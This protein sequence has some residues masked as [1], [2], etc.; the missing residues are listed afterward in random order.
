M[1][2]L[3]LD[4]GTSGARA[5]AINRSGQIHYHHSLPYQLDRET[6]WQ[7]AL[8]GLLAQIPRAVA[9]RLAKVLIAATS[10][11][12]LGVDG[13]GHP[14]TPILPYFDPRASQISLPG[15]QGN[16][17]ASSLAKL[18]WLKAH[19]QFTYLSH[20]A[21]YLGYLL[22]GQVGQSDYHNCL[23]L[24][25]DPVNLKFP[26]WI[27]QL[28]VW[29]Y[30]PQVSFPGRTVGRLLPSL[31]DRF[32]IAP[33]CEICAGTTDSTGAVLATLP[34][35]ALG[36]GITSL[37][38]TLVLKLVSDRPITDLTHGIY[39]HRL[40]YQGQTFYLV[41][42]ASNTGGA[43]LRHFFEDKELQAYSG[44]IDLSQPSPYDYY[45]LLRPGDRF[46]TNDPNLLPRLEP[47]PEDP[48]AF[49]YGLLSSIA[50][51]EA[52]GYKLLQQLTGTPITQIYTNG[53]GAANAT[54]TKIRS[55]YLGII[56][57]TPVQTQ[58]AYGAAKLALK[59]NP[60]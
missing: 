30:L 59:T 45:P 47:R 17:P 40:D 4:F 33:E 39:S 49:L 60:N 42:G 24:G 26:D 13:Q 53:G 55:T 44:L 28:P 5:I 19:Y 32:G 41:G 22:H 58:A 23:K 21:D 7:D 38:S 51:I 57:E 16:T 31:S 18:L 14:C 52:Q 12:V 50:K 6:T 56:P 15:D 9:A 48:I 43:V 35:L 3:G 54:W 46:P 2:F 34:E 29:S 8:F 37:G 25:Y 10:G 20:Q 27:T 11:T 36:V 1:Y